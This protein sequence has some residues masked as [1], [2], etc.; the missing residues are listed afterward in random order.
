MAIGTPTSL[1][2]AAATTAGPAYTHSTSAIV[3]SGALVIVVA[4]WVHNGAVPPTSTITGGGLTWTK[5]FE[6]GGTG[7]AAWGFAVHSAPAPSGLASATTLTL[8]LSDGSNYLANISVLYVTGLDVSGSRVDVTD[9]QFRSSTTTTWDTTAQATA[10]ANDLLIGGAYNDTNSTSVPLDS[11][12]ELFDFNDTGGNHTTTWK[13][14]AATG[15]QSL[16]G[17]W[18][19]TAGVD[20]S[21]FVAYKADG[22]GGGAAAGLAASFN[23]IPFMGGH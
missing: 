7:G 4:S 3:P 2:Y 18:S 11:A 17:T 6:N 10:N 5:D 22:G 16:A 14:V 19:G 21:G 1:G 12:N 20:I 15:L 23:P 13:I 8:T 9:G